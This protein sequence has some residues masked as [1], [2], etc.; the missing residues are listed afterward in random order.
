MLLPVQL[1]LVD[2]SLQEAVLLLLPLLLLRLAL[3]HS[4]ALVADW[5]L[6]SK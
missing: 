3:Q 2:L 4:F 6:V 5:D 1:L